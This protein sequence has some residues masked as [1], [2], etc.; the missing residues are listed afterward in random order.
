MRGGTRLAQM[1]WKQRVDRRRGG[2]VCGTV[3]GELL[4]FEVR[5]APRSMFESPRGRTTYLHPSNFE[6]LLLVVVV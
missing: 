3:E 1:G 5:C 6:F 2:R 4:G